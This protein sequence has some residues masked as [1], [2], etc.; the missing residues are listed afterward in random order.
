MAPYFEKIKAA[1]FTAFAFYYRWARHSPNNHTL[2][3]S[4]GAHDMTPLFELA[5]ELGLYIIV[6][7]GAYV[8]A[9]ANTGGLLCTPS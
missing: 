4:T 5:E 1:G 6:Q 2:D 3:L 7:P 9:E 8:N